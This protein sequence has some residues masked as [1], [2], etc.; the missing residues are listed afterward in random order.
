MGPMDLKKNGLG[1]VRVFMGNKVL[2]KA[3]NGSPNNPI[4]G[5][6]STGLKRNNPITGALQPLNAFFRTP[7]M[8]DYSI[9]SQPVPAKRTAPPGTRLLVT[10]GIGNVVKL[11]IHKHKAG[12]PG[13]RSFNQKCPQMVVQRIMQPYRRGL[14]GTYGRTAGVVNAA[15]GQNVEKID[16]LQGAAECS[17]FGIAICP[18]ATLVFSERKIKLWTYP[19]TYLAEVRLKSLKTLCII[20]CRPSRI[21]KNQPTGLC[22]ILCGKCRK[23]QFTGGILRPSHIKTAI[24]QAGPGAA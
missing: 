1:T 19:L 18:Q 15:G 9:S 16:F 5:A 2:D 20:Y 21:S 24:W 6:L 11:D 14:F 12:L 3:R 7:I 13:T 4:M 10:A 17:R 23:G 22:A 8:G